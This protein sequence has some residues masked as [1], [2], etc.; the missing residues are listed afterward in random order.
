MKHL[1]RIALA[2][3]LYAVAVY[4]FKAATKPQDLGP[5][6]AAATEA[7]LS[8]RPATA[9]E[10]ELARQIEERSHQLEL[11]ARHLE[12][13]EVA[14]AEMMASRREVQSASYAA[15]NQVLTAN[16]QHY[17]ELRDEAAKDARGQVPCTICDGYSYM[18]CVTCRDHDGKCITCKGTGR[19]ALDAYCPSCLGSGKCY[20]CTG[21]GK[22]FCP[23]C[24]DGVIETRRPPPSNFPPLF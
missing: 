20:L 19:I 24:N 22:M 13:L 10:Q 5:A 12:K 6:A 16:H 21:S 1:Y 3:A 23:F 8:H 2:L 17:L 15:W 7:S 4:V 11:Q 18:R 14:K 9:V